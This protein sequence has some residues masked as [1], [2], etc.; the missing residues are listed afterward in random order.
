MKS[1]VKKA[2]L[3]IFFAAEFLSVK[4]RHDLF[5][6]TEFQRKSDIYLALIMPI[7]ALIIILCIVKILQ[8]IKDD[9][10]EL[11]QWFDTDD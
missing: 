6:W 11:I 7:F 5:N 1:E 4:Y 9:I 2:L 3:I 8:A 10:K